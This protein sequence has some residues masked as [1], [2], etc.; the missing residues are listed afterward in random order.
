[1][2]NLLEKMRKKEWIMAGICAVLVLG[3]IYFG[4]SAAGLY[5]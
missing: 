3:Q 1:M 4:S 5:E 2:I